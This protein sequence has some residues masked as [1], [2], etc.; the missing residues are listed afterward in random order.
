MCVGGGGGGGRKT[1]QRLQCTLTGVP[2][3]INAQQALFLVL[4]NCT[5]IIYHMFS[6]S[7]SI[8]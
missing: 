1:I 3:I 6:K 8:T 2:L 4:P 7:N 5:L